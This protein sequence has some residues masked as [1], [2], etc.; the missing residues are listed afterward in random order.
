MLSQIY[1]FPPSQF[2]LEQSLSAVTH[3]AFAAGLTM[4]FRTKFGVETWSKNRA[5]LLNPCCATYSLIFC[6][7]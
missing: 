6:L 4:F 5:V 1:P 3:M 2:P 7:P